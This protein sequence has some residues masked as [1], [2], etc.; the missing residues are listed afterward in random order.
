MYLSHMQYNTDH[1]PT[2]TCIYQVFVLYEAGEFSLPFLSVFTFESIDVCSY[3]DDWGAWGSG[4]G[5]GRR[6][7]TESGGEKEGELLSLLLD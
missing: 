5:E 1:V 6:G 7:E 4:L 3:D 2:H